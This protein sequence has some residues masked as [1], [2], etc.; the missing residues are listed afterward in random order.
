MVPE[1]YVFAD[2]VSVRTDTGPHPT[3]ILDFWVLGLMLRG[4]TS[5]RI[6]E[7][8]RVVRSGEY[9]LLPSKQWHYGTNV[10]ESRH[11]IYFHFNTVATRCE[12]DEKGAVPLF[13]PLPNFIDYGALFRLLQHAID[14]GWIE[15]GHW[16]AQLAAI[17][18]QIEAMVRDEKGLSLAD[19]VARKTLDYLRQHAGGPLDREQMSTTLGYSGDHL[20]RIFRAT[21]DLTIYQRHAQLR[22]DRAAAL[23]QDGYS[24]K[25]VASRLGFGD[26]GYFLKSF[27]RERSISPTEYQRSFR[28]KTS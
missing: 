15:M 1:H 13:G 5:L 28:S 12:A 22:F 26:Y 25:E 9:Y 3:R 8:H 27:K 11:L 18:G 10:N 21:F 17:L 19:K 7:E 2:A 6:G 20:D 23:L 24:P 4:E 14:F 16:N